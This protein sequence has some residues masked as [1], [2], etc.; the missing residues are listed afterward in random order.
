MT[1]AV[2]HPERV[3]HLVLIDGYASFSDYEQGQ[4]LGIERAVREQDWNLSVEIVAGVLSGFEGEDARKNAEYVRACVDREAHIA[5]QQA[6]ESYDIT[7]LLGLVKVPTLVIHT[8]ANRWLPVEVGRRLAAGIPHSQL[9]LVDDPLV[10]AL[11][12]LLEEFMSASPPA[13]A[14]A[15]RE[16]SQSLRTVLFSDVV[17]HTAIM[18]RLGDERGRDVLREH[19]RITR[20]ALAQHGGLR[21]EDD[22]RRVYGV[23]RVGDEGVGVCDVASA[24]V[25]VTVGGAVEHSHRDQR[26]GADRGGR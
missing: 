6:I 19:E 10:R 26:G 7:P 16:A 11:P 15:Q 18:Q 2:A 14:A 24:S 5:S 1:F 9:I 3:S 17:G 8:K 22:G 25:R 13:P 20:E 12:V 21:S 4:A 23:V